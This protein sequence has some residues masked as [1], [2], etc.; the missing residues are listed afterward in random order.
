MG[1]AQFKQIQ[2]SLTCSLKGAGGSW[3]AD[4]SPVSLAIKGGT[5]RGS[6]GTES[7]FG[8]SARFSTT[9]DLSVVGALCSI[10]G[11][12]PTSETTFAVDWAGASTGDSLHTPQ[13]L[14]ACDCGIEQ[15]K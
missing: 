6:S 4:V 8:S 10:G 13:L 12:G 15:W 1:Y 5:K 2:E 11:V 14:H 9:G 3:R 7:T